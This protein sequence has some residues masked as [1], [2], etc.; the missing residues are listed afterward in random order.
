MLEILDQGYPPRIGLLVRQHINDEYD[1]RKNWHMGTMALQ[2]NVSRPNLSVFLNGHSMLSN[3]L[4]YNV[5]KQFPHLDAEEMLHYQAV[6]EYR[7]WY[8]K[9]AK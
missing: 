9:N 6:W 5:Q 4:A 8:S 7:R 3:K 1:G 2:L